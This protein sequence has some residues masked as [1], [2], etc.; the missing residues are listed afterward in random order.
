MGF[1]KQVNAQQAPAVEGDFCD[2]NPRY[3]VDAGPGGLVAGPNGVTVGRFAWATAPDDAN[4]APA[5]VSNAG[6]GP[7]TGFVHRAQ[8]GLIT[9]YLSDSGETVPAGF[10]VTL[11][12]G[13]GFWVKNAGATQALPGMKAYASYVDGS[14]TFAATGGGATASV[15]GSIAPTTASVTGSIA[16]DVLTVTAVSS[17]TL[18]NGATLSGTGGGGVATGTQ[19]VEQLSGTIGGVGTYLVS[20]PEQNVT[21]TT[22]AA[23]YGILTVTA[24]ASGTL[25]VG[26]VLSGSG[27]GGVTAGTTITQLGTGAGGNGT[28]MVSP[29]QTV[30][31]TT[32][33]GGTN[34]ETKWYAMSSGLTGELVKISD[35]ALG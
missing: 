15:T 13:G 10:P 34:V 8:Q 5:S 26:D 32:I 4:G 3:T 28:Y 12:S 35:K 23:A 2:M 17:G 29:S 18:V 20:I 6:E 9:T 11:H 24:V 22:I 16:N 33:T 31:S 21:S 7:V 1:Q 19:V 30:T 25:G 27:G 14:V